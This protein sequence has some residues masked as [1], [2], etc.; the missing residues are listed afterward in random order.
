MRVAIER[1]ESGVFNASYIKNAIMIVKTIGLL[2]L[3]G[4]SSTSIDKHLL[5]NYSKLAL[6]INNSEK[7]LELLI[8]HK[9]IRYASYKSS[10]ILFEGTDIDIEDELFKAASVVPMPNVNISDIIPYICLLYTSP[11]PRDS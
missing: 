5:I 4:S 10:Y 8:T 6:G 1:V 2:N 3:F 9:I 7:V 11:S